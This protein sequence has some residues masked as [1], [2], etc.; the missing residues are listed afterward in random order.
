MDYYQLDSGE[1]IKLTYELDFLTDND[2]QRHCR[3]KETRKQKDKLLVFSCN[4]VI[5]TKAPVEKIAKARYSPIHCSTGYPVDEPLG[6][7]HT[8]EKSQAAKVVPDRF[9]ISAVVA[10]VKPLQLVAVP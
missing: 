1:E 2:L 6:Q 7:L 10:V 8:V 4:G 9:F 5:H 3:N